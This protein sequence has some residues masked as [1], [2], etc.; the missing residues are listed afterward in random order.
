MAY[1]LI[2]P[3]K[4]KQMADTTIHPGGTKTGQHLPHVRSVIILKFKPR[5]PRF[6]LLLLLL[7]GCSVLTKSQMDS[8]QVYSLATQEYSQYPAQLINDFVE[9]QNSIFLLTSPLISDPERAAARIFSHQNHQNDILEEA[10][11]LDLSFTILKEYARNLEVLSTPDYF[12]KFVGN[13]KNTGTNL[14]LLVD[15]YNSRFDKKLPEGIGSLVY[16]S[17]VTVGQKS[18]A[19]QRGNILK[20]YILQGD[21]LIKEITQVTKEFLER[22][23]SDEWL[24]HI[25]LELKSGHTAVRSHIVTDTLSYP[26]NA[27]QIIQLDTQVD[28]LY[29]DIHQLKKLN[30]SLI[31]SI[32][33]LYPAHHAIT[34]DVQQK[35][36][37]TTLL[38][39]IA[40]FVAEVHKIMEQF[41]NEEKSLPHED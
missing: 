33:E 4:E 19:R 38:T 31:V 21:P 22:K 12:E 17:L 30:D 1:G 35:K 24:K 37:L 3:V 39:E 26:S 11:K 40:A 27:F 18:L 5:F 23:V 16:Q 25:D 29:K 36:K 10:E 6:L 9:V 32:D 2:F 8:I 7:S 14:D 41:R 28:Q 34:V 20:D 15:Q 13:I